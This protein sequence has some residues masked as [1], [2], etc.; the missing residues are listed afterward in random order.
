MHASLNELATKLDKIIIKVNSISH[1]LHSSALELLGLAVAVR[2]HCRE[3][4]EQLG[5]SGSL[6]L[7]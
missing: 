1:G 2:S 7:R 4:A 6:F 5:Y 3:C